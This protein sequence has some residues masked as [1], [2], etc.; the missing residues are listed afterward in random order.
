MQESWGPSLGAPD[1]RVVWTGSRVAALPFG[2]HGL[3]AAQAP[4]NGTVQGS[5]DTVPLFK[6][7]AGKCHCI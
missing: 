1:D 5:C 6:I 7:W 4:K 2:R 3:L